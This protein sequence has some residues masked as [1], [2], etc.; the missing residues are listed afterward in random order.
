MP[1][2]IRVRCANPE[3][4]KIIIED[5]DEKKFKHEKYIQCCYCGLVMLNSD[6]EGE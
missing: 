4:K 5:Y 1:E 6:Y 3:C 2:K